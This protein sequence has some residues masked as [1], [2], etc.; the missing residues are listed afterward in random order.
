MELEAGRLL[1]RVKLVGVAFPAHHMLV[2]SHSLDWGWCPPLVVSHWFPLVG[3]MLPLRLS[4][5]HGC[6][7]FVVCF[8]ALGCPPLVAIGVGRVRC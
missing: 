8:A 4:V 6:T 5:P 2:G 3:L 7:L 1:T